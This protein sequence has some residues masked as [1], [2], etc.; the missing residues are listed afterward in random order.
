MRYLVRNIKNFAKYEKTIFILYILCICASTIIINFAYG[1]SYYLKHKKADEANGIYSFSVDVYDAEKNIVTIANI[2]DALKK[3]DSKEIE[4]CTIS[5]E[6]RFREDV[7]AVSTIDNSMLVE[8]VCFRLID[9]EIK[10]APIESGWQESGVIVDGDYF[11]SEQYEN[12]ELVCLASA[13]APESYTTQEEIK[14][15]KKYSENENGICYVDGKSYKCIGHVSWYSC[16][17]MVP[18]TTLDGD[19]Y[20]QR[21]GF[22]F[23]DS[24]G[25][26][27][28]D[29]I[30]VA[31]V[32][33]FGD[34]V[35]VQELNIA[36]VG[37]QSFYSF[38]GVLTFFLC[39][40]SGIVMSMLY[41]YIL[42]KRKK[43]LTV[44]RLCG[45]IRARAIMLYIMENLL[46]TIAVYIISTIL[47]SKIILQYLLRSFEHMEEPYLT[48]IYVLIGLAYMACVMSELLFMIVTQVKRNITYDLRG[49]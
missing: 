14:W 28:Y 8:F 25:R 1:F 38:L 4:N 31:L 23:D 45:L 41:E 12:G 6:V 34:M 2:L 20:V 7:T 29:A 35:G 17:P 47:Y 32:S 39:I 27:Q 21:I 36:E 26:K 37:N 24:L 43:M 19:E 30:R 42:L 11:T 16:V 22:E 33:E 13:S 15:A 49:E 18:V 48:K 5:L 9:G 3:V 44:Y 46:I 10:N 40:A